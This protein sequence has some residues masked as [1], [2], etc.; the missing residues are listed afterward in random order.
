MENPTLKR[1]QSSYFD[2]PQ[3]KQ[4]VQVLGDPNK[5]LQDAWRVLQKILDDKAA[6]KDTKRQE[7]IQNGS[8]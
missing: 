1:K 6:T 8:K 4:K 7:Q 5:V 2:H 3:H